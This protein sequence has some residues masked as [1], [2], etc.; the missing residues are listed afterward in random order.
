MQFLYIIFAVLIKN[1]LPTFH[2]RCQPSY[3]I[4]RKYLIL[5]PRLNY[6]NFLKLKMAAVCYLGFSKTWIWTLGPLGLPIFHLGTTFG[7]KMLIDA[8]I[9]DQ[10]RNPRWRPYAILYFWKP[11][12]WA[13]GHLGLPNFHLNT[14]KVG[15]KMLIEAEIMAQNRNPSW[16]P[17]AILDFRKSDFW[18]LEPLELL[19]FHHC[20][21][22]GAKMLIDAKIIAKNRNPIWRQS[23]I[24]D[25]LRHDIWPPTKSI[26]WATSAFQILC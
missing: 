20:T 2:C 15:A 10:N 1:I 24:L 9:I 3:K 4:S 17:S 22:F 12:F 8:K 21:K 14:T 25:L 16:R 18:A 26:H 11:D 6:N 7:S 13:M 23:A 5:N 19:I